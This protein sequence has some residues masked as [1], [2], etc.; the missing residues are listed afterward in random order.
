MNSRKLHTALLEELFGPIYLRILKQEGSLRMVHLLD[1]NKI[2]RTMGIV[3][4]RN[5]DHPVIK[6]AHG[7]ILAG[8]LLGKTLHER[9]IPYSKDM[10][11]QLEVCLP[12]WVSRDFLSDRETTVANYSKITIEDRVSGK[13]FLYADLF[14]IIP[15]EIIHLVPKP[16]MTHQAEAED[17]S[18]LLNFAGITMALNDSEL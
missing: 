13:R 8:A 15:P 1:E 14:E 17:C 5:T 16:P 3:H 9:D 6:A 12:E 2:S 11:Y 4:F 10:L 7:C 18:D